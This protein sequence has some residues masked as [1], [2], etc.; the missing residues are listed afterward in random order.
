[1]NGCDLKLHLE[2]QLHNHS[3]CPR[4][5]LMSAG[6]WGAI[7]RDHAINLLWKFGAGNLVDSLCTL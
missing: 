4:V 7:V 5:S 1:M 3:E 2:N 6:G